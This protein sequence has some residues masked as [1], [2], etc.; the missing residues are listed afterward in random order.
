MKNEER[1]PL[2]KEKQALI[3]KICRETM[4]G[5]KAFDRAF[6]EVTGKPLLHDDEARKE[7]KR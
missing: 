1:K 2:S 3:D 4:A 5:L 7:S 6:K